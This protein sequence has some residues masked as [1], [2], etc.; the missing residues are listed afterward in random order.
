MFQPAANFAAFCASTRTGNDPVSGN[1]Y[2][3]KLG[4][5]VWENNWL[6]AWTHQYYL[7]T[8][9]V[10]DVN[11]AGHS[12]KDYFDLMKTTAKTLSGA[13]ED[14]FH[15][16]YTTTAW[17]QLS[18][19]N[20]SVGYGVTW[21]LLATSPP[22]KLLVAYS[23]AGTPAATNNLMRG[24]TVLTIDGV[25]VVNDGTQAGVDKLNA[26]LYP[27]TVGESHTFIVE[28]TPGGAQRSITMVSQT[29]TEDPVPH[30]AT[31]AQ[32]SGTVGYIEFNAHVASAESELVAAFTQLNTARV[33]D[34]VLDIRYNGGG[35]LD[36]ASE[37]AYMV[38]GPTKTSGL[39]FEKETFNDPSA[40]VNPVTGQA[41]T[42]TPFLSTTSF[43]PTTGQALPHLDLP[44]V[45]VLTTSNT[46][47]ASEAIINGLRGVGVTVIEIGSTTCGKPYGFYP[48]DNCGTTYFSIEFKGENNAG[49]GDY[50]DG[51]S[52][53]GGS[54]PQGVVIP[55]C[56]VNDDYTHQ[57][58][59]PAEGLLRS[60]LGYQ[61]TGSCPAAA[62]IAPHVIVA[63]IS[64]PNALMN[65]IMRRP[66]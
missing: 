53:T 21:A 55:G 49:F 23:D 27:A 19:S 8:T 50:P 41:L 4:S 39:T 11:P 46:C 2:P 65:R 42:P 37:V 60:A 32:P 7:W 22:R 59:D 45:F 58:G 31:I 43:P 51:F 3:D 18:S 64:R 9:E 54:A 30:T 14:R 57:L 63:R 17:E 29:V 38:A 25:D 44:R 61:A 13:D 26:G 62:A 34:L 15:F 66:N 36:I 52:P 40:T 35:Y 24:A 33:T 48:Q 10:T 16:T 6:R 47:S 1:A 12:T 20:A 56:A 5:V 28:D